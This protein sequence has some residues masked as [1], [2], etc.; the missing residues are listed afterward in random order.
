L[1]TTVARGNRL[2]EGWQ[3][4]IFSSNYIGLVFEAYDLTIYSLLVVPISKYFNVP[5]WYGFL[6][7]AMTYVLRGVGGLVFGHV[8]D[9]IGR[10]NALM[11][12]VLGYSIATALTGLSWSVTA[13]LVWRALTGLFIGGEYVSYSYTMESVP[14]DKR[15]GFS[16]AIVTSYSVGFLLA[17]ATFG[18]VTAIMGSGFA[19]GGGWRWPFF[20][21]ILPALIALWL[22]LGV[23]ESPAWQRV[24]ESNRQ[25]AKVPLFEIFKPKYLGTTLHAWAL[26][27]ALIWAYDVLILAFPTMLNKLGV[28]NNQ[29][30]ELLLIV[31]VGSLIAAFLGGWASQRWGRRRTLLVIAI[32]GIVFTP[33]FAPFWMRGAPSFAFLAVFGFIGALFAEGGFG[34]MPAYL[35]ERYPTEVRATG[36]TGTY[37]LGQIIAGWSLTIMAAMF[38]GN[39]G[40]WMEGMLIN[41]V[42]GFVV[43]IALVLAGRE[44]R[45]VDLETFL[46]SLAPSHLIRL[47][48]PFCGRSSTR[49]PEW[50]VISRIPN[51]RFQTTG[52]RPHF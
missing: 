44:T 46:A 1:S 48:T 2:L 29:I 38:A 7:L 28:P 40:R 42:I 17:S 10:R 43:L 31:N 11:F 19:A 47:D 33:L 37:N 36:A 25:R 13:L 32:L 8:A 50:H 39:A 9:K 22:R 12:T 52:S 24:H 14:K 34:I 23:P 45:E 20:V 18:I 4:R 27:A 15:G 35:S 41:A 16:G 51:L 26:M 6:V 21:G 5:V 3:W 49:R 30:S